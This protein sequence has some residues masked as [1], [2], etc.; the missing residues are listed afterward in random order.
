MMLTGD[1]GERGARG[2]AGAGLAICAKASSDVSPGEGGV[3]DAGM[4]RA[5]T[6]GFPAPGWM[7]PRQFAVW[8]LGELGA[9]GSRGAGVA[10]A[11]A[12]ARSAAHASATASSAAS[13][14]TGNP[15]RGYRSANIG[16][17][18]VP[19]AAI[20]KHPF[21]EWFEATPRRPPSRPRPPPA[22]E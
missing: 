11:Q 12:A 9:R 22:G 8:M 6:A 15:S 10:I 4:Q 17:P 3:V 1:G 2:V 18:S 5:A 7:K 21:L 14:C 16:A 13:Q 19:A 20:F